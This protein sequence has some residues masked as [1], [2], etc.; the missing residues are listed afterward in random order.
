[1]LGK[2]KKKIIVMIKKKA[3]IKTD[4]HIVKGLSSSVSLECSEPA[5]RGCSM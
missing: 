1:M 2:K 3:Q 5:V 4:D